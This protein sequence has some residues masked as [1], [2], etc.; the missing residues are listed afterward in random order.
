MPNKQVSYNI[1]C[2]LVSHVNFLIS[3]AKLVIEK[4]DKGII[5]FLDF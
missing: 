4:K 1:Y 5:V 2:K 3:N